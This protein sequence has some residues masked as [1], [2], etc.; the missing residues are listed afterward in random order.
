MSG[1]SV[2]SMTGTVPG[3]YTV[4]VVGTSG[5]ITR[6][7]TVTARVVVPNVPPP[8]FTQSN[9]KQRLSLSKDNNTGTWNIGIKNMSGNTTIYAIVVINAIDGSGSAPFTL[10][11][12]IITL[13]PNKSMTNI[14]LMKT[15]TNADIGESFTF[16]MVILWGTSPDALVFQSN[17]NQ[18]IRTSGS[19][20][21][22]P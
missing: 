8:E 18:G 19:F 4:T 7:V 12:S 21:I 14:Q 6:V 22:L 13:G 20:T 5:T 9:W 3:N 17:I 16:N 2:L 1:S 10:T 11:S 15:F